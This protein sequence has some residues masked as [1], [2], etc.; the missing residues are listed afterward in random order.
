MAG[1]LTFAQEDKYEHVVDGLFWQISWVEWAG[2]TKMPELTPGS[3][4]I[5]IAE[6]I[7]AL[8]T[9]E[10]FA[11]YCAGKITLLEIDNITAKAWLDTA[12]CTRA[13]YD[14][15]AQ[16]SHLH[17]LKMNMKIKT[18]WIPSS[19]NIVADAC[20]RNALTFKSK[21]QLYVLAGRQFRRIS[22]K[23]NNLLKYC[24]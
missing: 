11:G 24:K 22:P 1:V 12:R 18:P 17:R 10:T 21:G 13:P 4:K 6:F 3:V 5:N 19:Q 9:C 8:I 7:A 15:C 2:M 16:G 20:S 14:R 23:L